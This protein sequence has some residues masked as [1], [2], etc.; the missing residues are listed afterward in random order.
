MDVRPV[1]ALK[2]LAQ[3]GMALILANALFW[4]P[5]LAN[6]DGIVV[7]GPGTTVGQAGNGVPV[8]NIAT[9]NGSGLSHNQFK[10]YNVGP[11][12]VILNNAT[13]ALQNTQ[14]GG[15]I[16]GNSNLKNGAASVILNE[17]KGGSPSQL[18]G[19]TEVAGQS[20]KVIVANPYGI[21]CNG[22]GFIN[23]PNVTLTTGKPVIDKVGRLDHYQVDG[24]AV[25]IDGQ[26]LNA[27]NVDRFEIITRSAKIN[28][29]INAR[30][31][32]VIAG[33]N[34]VDAQSL[35]TTVRADDG[36]EKPELAIDSSALG[37]MY[38]GAIKLVGTEAGV[39]V[40]LDGTL[41]ASGGDIQLDANGHLSMAQASADGAVEI[42]AASL[43]AHGPVY[44]GTTL[45]AQTKG[46]LKNHKILAAR[47][48]ITLASNGRLTNNGIIE[49][50]VNADNTRNAGGD[51][52]LDSQH[53][54]NTG[55]VIANR[56]LTATVAQSVDNKGGTVSARQALNITAGSVDNRNKGQL[57]SDGTQT[58]NVSGLLDNS[59][60]GIIDSTGAFTLHGNTLDNSTGNLTGASSITL[61]LLGDLINRNGK[62][63]SVGPLLVQRAAHVDNRGGKIASQGLLTLFANSVDNQ[64]S[65]T[66]AANDGLA[67]TTT[68]LLQNG[69]N[70]L[71]HSEKAGITLIAGTLDNDGGRIAAKAG[72]ASVDATDFNNGSGNLF[73]RD[74]ILLRGMNVDNGGEIAANQIDVLLHG[75]LVNRGLIESATTL[76]VD[77]ASLTNS[78]QMRALGATGKTRY[79]IGG[80]LNNSGSLETAN[81]QLSLAAGSFQ[82]TGGKVLHVGTGVLDLSG[83]SLDDVGGSLVTQGD[84]T[85]DKTS[86]TN[87][88][89][90]QAG[91]LTVNVT[92][93]QQTATGKL[94]GTR[95]LVGKG[96]DWT[97][98]GSVA[99]QGTLDLS[100]TSLLNDHGLIF[101]GG[102]MGLRVERLKN[103]GAAIYAMGNLRIDRDGQGGRAESIINSS[104]SIE[105]E[106]SLVMAAGRIEN[107]RTVLT[108]ES[109]I[110]SASITPTACIFGVTGSDCDGGKETWPFLI[111][112]RDRFVV[113]DASAASSIT[114]A[115]HMAL[116]GDTLLNSS[117]SIAAGGNLTVAVNQLS[118]I[119]I[120]TH[121]IL[122]ERIFATKRDRHPEAWYQLA[123]AFNQRYTMG[124]AGYDANNLSG[125]EGALAAFIGTTQ[126]EWGSRKIT[127]LAPSDQRYAAVIQAGG[128]VDVKAQAGIDNSVVR[129]GYTYVGSGANTNA[130]G[131]STQVALNP[132]LPPDVA[133]QQVNPLSLPG[134]DLPTGENGL[135]HLN[136]GKGVNGV[137]T[138]Q[139]A[140]NPHKYLIETNPLLTDMRQFLSSDYML[141]KLGYDPE[142]AQRRL[143]D[144][145]YE[146]RLIQ[147]AV[148]ART[149]QRFIDGQTSD[150]ELFKHLMD[151]A[152]GSKDALNLSVGVSL[153]AEQVAALTHD[154]VWLENATVAGQQVLVPVLYMAQANNRLGPNGA[155][156]SGTDVNL[157]TGSNLNNAG[158]LRASGSLLANV[159]GNLS[160][161]GLMQADNRL[162]LL[163]GNNLSN[164]AGGVIAGGAVNLAAGADLLNER[165]VTT[166]ESAS[167][168]RTERK[169]FGDSAARIE[170]ASALAL[171]AGGTLNNVGGVLKSG[172]DTTVQA[173]GDVNL[174][175]SKTLDSG[176]VGT[177]IRYTTV[178]QQGSIIDAGRDLHVVAGRDISVVASQ[179][180]AKR[181]IQ[182]VA[183]GNLNAVAGANE[184][185]SAYD[186]KK[187][188]IIEDH[189][190]QVSSVIKA[191][192]DATL[193]AGQD[194]QLVASQVNA[195]NEAYL[196][197]GKNLNLETAADQDYSFFSKTKKTS[198]GKKFRLDETDAVNHVGSLVS[199]GTHSTLMAGE[200][201]LLA[202]STVT[203]DKGA[204]Q[205]V[206][207]QDVSILAVSNSD[208]ARHE[209]KESKSS[210]GGLKSSKVQ[211]Q[212]DEKRTTAMGSMVSGETVTV[213]AKRDATVTGSALVSTGDLAV[214][215]GRDLT[216]DAA[217]NTFARTDMHKEKN[218]DLTG[219]LTGNSLGLDDLTGNQKL[220]I[221]SSKH[222]GTA[223]EMTLTGSTIGSS[224]GNVSLTAGREL[225]VVA[226]DLV[227]TKN[228]ALTGANVTITSGMETASQTSQDS[229]K[230]L[231]VGRV[232][233]G[234]V[235]DTANSIR[236]A[237]EAA[238][239]SD[240]PRLKAVKIAQAAL[241]LYNLNNQAGEVAK[242]ST[243]FKDKTGGSAGNGSLIK[244]GTELANT[245]TKSSSEYTAQTAHQSSLNA[246]ENLS[247]VAAGDAPGTLG[248]LNITGSSLK[249]DSLLLSAKNNIVMQ[250]AQDTTDRKNDG[251]R[252]RT[253]IGAS[254][255]I[256]EQNGFTLD[257]GAQTAKNLGS[258]GSVTQVNTTVDARSLLLRSGQ[259]T[260]LAGA[261]V[262][263]DRIDADIGGNLTV[264]SRQDTDTSRSKQDSAGFG[265]SICIPPFCYGS[266]VS[267]SANLAASKMNS[268][269]QAVTDQSG[270]FAGTGGYTIDVAKNTTLQGAVIASEATADKN[271]L[272]TDRLL[273]SD[274]KNKSEIKSQSAGVSV[275]GT[276]SG[277]V[278]TLSPGAL[279]G[280]ALNDSD[281]SYTRSAVSEGTIVVRNPEGANDLVGLNRD[282]ANANEHLDK[283]DQKAMQERMDLIK[284][285][286][287]LTKGIGDAIAAARIKAANDENSDISK[288]TK[289]KLIDEGVA[290]PTQAQISQRAQE[291][292]GVGSSFQKASQAVTAVVQ[293]AMGG[294]IGGAMAGAAAPYLAQT[295]KQITEGDPNAN[296]MAHAVLGAVLARAG[297]NSALAGAAGALAAEETA[298]LIKENLYGN[299]SSD[300]LTPAQKQTISSLSTLAA[301]L[302][303]SLSG[304]GALDAVAAAQTGKNAVENN[305]LSVPEAKR[306]FSLRYKQSQGTITDA[307][308]EELVQL[309]LTDKSRDSAIKAACTPGNLSSTAC[310]NLIGPAQKA[311]AQYDESVAVRLLY[312]ELYPA[313]AKNAEAA[314]RGLSAEHI[315]R[316]VVLNNLTEGSGLTRAEMEQRYDLAMT[317]QTVVGVLAG[318]YGL[319]GLGA[320]SK[321]PT[322]ALVSGETKVVGSTKPAANDA[323]FDVPKG[324][325]Q[326]N[327]GSVTGPG[328]G[329]YKATGTQDATGNQIYLAANGNYYTLT[330]ERSTRIASP[331][332]PSE[333]GSTGKV[334]E[335][336]LKPLG[337]Q[338]Q[339]FFDTSLGPRFVDQLAP[340]AK[341]H[342]SKVGYTS[343]DANT[344][345]QVA[346]DAEL[347]QRG[348][349]N[350]VTWNFFR[351]PITG[352]VGPAP[353]LEK[354]LSDA[355]IKIKV[356]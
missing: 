122:S 108:T 290:S 39:G 120:V 86:W 71:I 321:V 160:N 127:E 12:G 247:I 190:Q 206:A 45:K 11:N 174:T 326:A 112:E 274:I 15:I 97:I 32:T 57:L 26:G 5:L 225:T 141:T 315:L 129:P 189:V 177:S 224:A 349:V 98:G 158:T 147:Q 231:A 4:Q 191:G 175:A 36:S 246:G 266:T 152:I 355:G 178:A 272:L 169:D 72:D 148:L 8:V 165:T 201:L 162:D 198:Q 347:I 73:A 248:D 25:T 342:E 88:T 299:V 118:N 262:R 284:S 130:P 195:G 128:A 233:A 56:T 187:V 21:S 154:I 140:A 275:S 80:L 295:V 217:Q 92:H 210:W 133:Q 329:V 319:R 66:L 261:Q 131:Y 139:F 277:G 214:Q 212:V 239:S 301:G 297:G 53:L 126:R 62:L 85:L 136:D 340:G 336:A 333:I 68:G 116:T 328:G 9:P 234:T 354:A 259:D 167:G 254:F 260:T 221:N 75:A 20:A 182:L 29:K 267:A 10:D 279:Y 149:G 166:H 188:K 150:A 95:S 352:R 52:T 91:R 24:G 263:A 304:K 61:D 161:S 203:A 18:R 322:T 43:D 42:K 171:K 145:F 60:G 240:D 125:L 65:G 269:Y 293:A 179:V 47:D 90:I 298:R 276:Y 317:L 22:C 170:S 38:A 89:A 176:N 338:S 258:G 87:S 153:T 183:T 314:L 332:P 76:D 109:G 356:H 280:M 102:D 23:T 211:D 184:Q 241:S 115:S 285:S 137:P 63:A 155:L 227:S 3:R 237:A 78:G 123:A 101:S 143:G 223:N 58:L 335:D 351:S 100:V 200:N 168:Y 330:A 316:D 289:Q 103:L 222:N 17:V 302:S 93:L 215:A 105:T 110:Y 35:K 219:V 132:Q 94:L 270:F 121:D 251:S 37:G 196:V 238:R 311:L 353:A 308:K 249:A 164:R 292:Y 16:V 216:I 300:N 345:L 81:T 268:D 192:G 320:G 84:L 209:R 271:L 305:Y 250:S 173:A 117:S 252:N 194:L 6:A 296:L 199:A 286:M 13:G 96:E 82:N 318:G 204:T 243:G 309:D 172:A 218:R 337:G 341:A 306:K 157:I 2:S 350:D 34:D 229:S 256:G 69:A 163:A 19:Y 77:T 48:S 185:H 134:F 303:G 331:N 181:D 288:A 325:T 49:A 339:A 51:V 273:V 208:S 180:E 144:G 124:A 114:S 28:A 205:L 193:S 46:E 257:L 197:A 291:D 31:L 287:E 220:Y 27:S 107:I 346:K 264:L 33:R 202:G 159:A 142:T 244:I 40:K 151:N 119:G 14:L 310:S 313:D 67:L 281:H 44:A 79:A 226:S 106:G 41:A 228:M 83:I 344:A 283:P 323:S 74:R 104:S 135:F 1:Y 343:L 236:D 207:G 146:Q 235:V 59:Q 307:E 327:D 324:Y 230:S 99:S 50:G 312:K 253:A 186:S 265:A 213:A 232:I 242:Q 64:N 111:S 138:S 70:G 156:I 30:Q 54:T 294:S 282:T 55:S 7:S 113:T 278:G 348:L 334:G 255:N 245:R